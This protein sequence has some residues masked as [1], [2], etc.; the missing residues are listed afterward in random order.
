MES[1]DFV[2]YDMSRELYAKCHAPKRLVTVPD[3]G[4]GL[5]YVVDNDS[6]FKAVCEFFT[7]NG[8]A[9]EVVQ[10]PI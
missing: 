3:A 9:T 1:D 2:P 4:H 10:K 7:K 5:V 6:Y 8:V